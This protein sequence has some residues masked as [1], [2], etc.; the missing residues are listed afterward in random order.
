MISQPLA[1]HQLKMHNSTGNSSRNNRRA[2][3]TP[4]QHKLQ[5][6]GG[7]DGDNGENNN[8]SPS[9]T[10][11]SVL[12]LIELLTET[13][14]TPSRPVRR[15]VRKDSVS[16]PGK[17]QTRTAA[18]RKNMMAVSSTK[19]KAVKPTQ[20]PRLT[21]SM[22]TGRSVKGMR[23]ASSLDQIIKFNAL[24]FE[25]AK[26]EKSSCSQMD[27][28]FFQENNSCFGDFQTPH[29]SEQQKKRREQLLDKFGISPYHAE[30][31]QEQQ[32]EYSER[33]YT[34]D[35][36]ERYRRPSN[37]QS[38]RHRRPSNDDGERRRRSSNPRSKKHHRKPPQRQSSAEGLV[39]HSSS[40]I[41]HLRE[42]DTTRRRRKSC[43]SAGKI[44]NKRT[45]E[46]YTGF[47]LTS[48]G[49]DSLK[50]GFG[51]TRFPDGR[52]FEGLYDRGEMV[53]GKMTYPKGYQGQGSVTTYIGKFD[54]DGLR[55]GKAIYI[56]ATTTFLG[57]FH[58]DNQE[59][60]GI[61]IYHDGADCA[62]M[63]GMNPDIAS[64]HRRFVG[65]WRN[66]VRHGYGKEILV[67]GTVSEE[68]FWEKG[69]WVH[70]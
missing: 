61:L 54:K 21:K 67:D 5:F 58:K 51:I 56:T 29:L 64:H 7:H 52:V 65:H 62:E 70:S 10:A 15:R 23:R 32:E 34:S 6:V 50:N 44:R 41:A 20:D 42:E 45:K 53:E 48:P 30:Q 17:D 14:V 16:S 39:L 22:R 68:G 12:E 35:D 59:G 1:S 69:A 2:P 66:G 55:R 57:Q 26:E 37:E 3:F 33:S 19:V 49:E 46:E 24:P 60:S 47:F 38:E 43:N 36:G 11:D 31:N 28:S 18:L 63:V 40:E 9:S 27:N 13:A 8:S 25:V 4:M